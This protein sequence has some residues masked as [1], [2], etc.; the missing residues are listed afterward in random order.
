MDRQDKIVI[1]LMLVIFGGSLIADIILNPQRAEAEEQAQLQAR[2]EQVESVKAYIQDCEDEEQTR[3]AT[4]QQIKAEK[5]EQ[6]RQE[7]ARLEAERQEAERLAREQAER[8]AEQARQEAMRQAQ[9]QQ[10]QQVQ[11][12][13]QNTATESATTPQSGVLTKEGG[14]NYFNGSRETWYSS[15]Q[16]Y[17]YRTNEWTAGADGVYRDKDGYVVVARSDMAQGA[18]LETSLGTG[19]VYDS[20]CANG[21]TDIYTKW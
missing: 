7:A 15:N 14:V 13:A 18:T 9:L 12:Q 21:T 2:A 19:K 10:A 17:H 4:N 3:E 1:L 5:A 6:A 8:E 16:L 11:A 20:G